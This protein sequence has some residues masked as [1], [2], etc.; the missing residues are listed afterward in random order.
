MWSETYSPH[1]RVSKSR[2][3][4]RSKG[5]SRRRSMG[6]SRRRSRGKS[7][8]RSRGKSMEHCAIPKVVHQIWIGGE[9]PP[10]LSLYMNDWKEMRGWDYRLWGN[11]DLNE[12]NFPKTWHLIKRMLRLE[13]PVYAMIADLMRLEI[14]YHHGGVYLDTTFEKVRNITPLLNKPGYKF[15]M[16]NEIPDP[17]LELPFISNSFIASVPRYVVLRRLLSEEKLSHI[18]IKGLANEQTGPYYVRTGIKR[19]SEVSLIPTR[20]IYPYDIR[21]I[22]DRGASK[23]VSN[24]WKPGYVRYKFFRNTYYV[25]YPC[26]SEFPYAYMIK[27]WNIGGTWIKA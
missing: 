1:K 9:L 26:V 3:S 5:K 20:F 22:W 17:E 2:S 13:R 15:A 18:N 11:D 4:R 10:I 7:R 27:Q 16:S 8:R 14:L 21:T 23:C 24:Y 19:P 12:Q 6:K 25:K